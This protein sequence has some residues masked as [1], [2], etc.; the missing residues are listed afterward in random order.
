MVHSRPSTF[1]LPALHH[2]FAFSRPI[3]LLPFRTFHI[4]TLPLIL[5]DTLA[6]H[7]PFRIWA[8]SM[9]CPASRFLA[10]PPLCLFFPFRAFCFLILPAILNGTLAWDPPFH[11]RAA[12]VAPPLRVSRP[13]VCCM[14]F[15]F[16]AFC[17]VFSPSCPFLVCEG[18]PYPDL[19]LH[20]LYLPPYSCSSAFAQ[21]CEYGV[22]ISI[23]F[24]L[25]MLPIISF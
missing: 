5:N 24:Y 23:Q 21:F 19:M 16:G 2:R 10:P 11:I 25:A 18:H 22:S 4:P 14:L 7:P 15:P 9:H 3:A 1:G 20:S 12:S 6:W 17:C 13:S 8:A